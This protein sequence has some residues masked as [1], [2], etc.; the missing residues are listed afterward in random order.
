[1]NNLGYSYDK[2]ARPE[3][4][5]PYYEQALQGRRRAL[6]EDHDATLISQSN[7]GTLY[8]RLGRL[9]D[10]EKL[11]T[12]TLAARRRIHGNDHSET[13]T[14]ITLL[15]SF[16]FATKQPE[17]TEPLLAEVIA[18]LKRAD[19]RDDNE[20]GRLLLPH[21]ACLNQLQRPAQAKQ[22]WLECHRLLPASRDPARAEK[23]A[24]ALAALY[25]SQGDPEKAAPWRT[26]ASAASRPATP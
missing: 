13:H 24:N 17:K 20:I 21:G 14:A 10:A 16:Y 15:A 4:A 9:A 2:Q 3:E 25:E 23:L 12:D 6:G 11:L 5:A 1:M 26:L 8:Q 19:P 18:L 7:L 22:V